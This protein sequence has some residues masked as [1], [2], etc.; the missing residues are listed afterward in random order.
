MQPWTQNEEVKMVEL[1]RSGVSFDN[2]AIKFGRTREEI[3][4]KVKQII[5]ENIIDG[6]SIN[7]VSKLLKLPEDKVSLYFDTYREYRKKHD[8]RTKEQTKEPTQVGGQASN[9]DEKIGKIER[10]NRF[11]KSVIENR[12]LNHKLNELIKQGVINESIRVTITNL[13]KEERLDKST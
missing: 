11:I 7:K 3:E 9:F 1:I 8:E 5:Y 13:R 4:K 6:K 2:I 10:E 12:V